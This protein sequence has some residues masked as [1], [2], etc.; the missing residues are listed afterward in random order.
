MSETD[1]KPN[2][3]EC[4]IA[5]TESF[6]TEFF[7]Q[8]P[9]SQVGVIMTKDG[10]AEKVSELGGNPTDHIAAIK[11]REMRETSGEPS[12]QNALTLACD[13]LCHVPTHG[14]RE[15]LVIWASLTTCDPGNIFETLD[16]LKKENIRVSIIS[17]SAEV[18]ICKQ[19]ANDTKGSYG[20]VLNESHFKDLLFENLSPPA[21]QSSKNFTNMIQMGFPESTEFE[22]PVL[23]VW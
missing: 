22:D 15:I 7:D 18:K 23:C 19:I 9:I 8:N 1:L 3:I 11:K 20:V 12:L 2:R 14:S 17:L 5:T 4:A 21:I 6:I 16:R 13:S 10:V